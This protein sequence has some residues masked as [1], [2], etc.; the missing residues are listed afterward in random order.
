MEYSG[1]ETLVQYSHVY[2]EIII[3]INN[4][5]RQPSIIV[6]EIDG[7]KHFGRGKTAQEF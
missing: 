5:F 7:N 4:I 2:G 3:K 1:E 6:A